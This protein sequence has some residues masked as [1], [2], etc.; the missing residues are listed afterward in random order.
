MRRIAD[1]E[2]WDIVAEGA[3]PEFFVE[4]EAITQ[5]DVK[6]LA[7]LLDR[8]RGERPVQ[9]FLQC[10]PQ[11]MV[12][13]VRGGWSRWVIPQKRM[14]DKHVTDFIIGERDSLGY[15]WHAVELES[16]TAK[17]FTQAGDPSAALT[18]AIRQVQDW[19][20]WLNNNLEY[21]RRDRVDGGL[22][23]RGIRPDVPAKIFI[24]RRSMLDSDTQRRREQMSHDS[25]IEIHTFDHLYDVAEL[26]CDRS[27][28][29]TR[30][31]PDQP[32]GTTALRSA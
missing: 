32:T 23:L 10:H 12:Q 15:H 21:A 8:G 9:A 28:R 27:P 6:E 19:R 17:L 3:L 13:L 1:Y 16:P 5:H 4:W 18:H 25:G 7:R 14:G 2:A 29:N 22:E 24:G 20:S 26:W 11:V 31:L 30:Q